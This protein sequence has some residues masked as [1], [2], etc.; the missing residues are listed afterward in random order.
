M[1]RLFLVRSNIFIQIVFYMEELIKSIEKI[2]LIIVLFTLAVG[3]IYFLVIRPIEL[4]SE[5]AIKSGDVK[6]SNVNELINS[7]CSQQYQCKKYINALED[8]AFASHIDEC[9]KIKAPDYYTGKY[10][11]N[12]HGQTLLTE[13]YKEVEDYCRISNLIQAK[14]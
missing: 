13:K 7:L 8:C 4:V 3:L 10:I 6:N 12:E 14:W 1:E 9:V 11:C 2:M 5:K